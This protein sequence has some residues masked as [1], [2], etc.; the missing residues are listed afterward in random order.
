MT[1]AAPARRRVR[2][3]GVMHPDPALRAPHGALGKLCIEALAQQRPVPPRAHR[4]Q[5]VGDGETVAVA[6]NA[7]L[8]DLADPARIFLALRI[9]LVEVV[10]APA[11]HDPGE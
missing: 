5:R 11:Q 8:A 9:A 3:R 2:G 1:L 4:E 6:G 10:T 7:E